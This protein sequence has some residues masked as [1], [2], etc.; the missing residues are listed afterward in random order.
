MD[1]NTSQ[2]TSTNEPDSVEKRKEFT[3]DLCDLTVPTKASMEFH[4]NGTFSLEY[5]KI[6]KSLFE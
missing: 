2:G 1:S 6:D 5:T 3:C 4:L